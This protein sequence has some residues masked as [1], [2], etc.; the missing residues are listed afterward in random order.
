MVTTAE[1]QDFAGPRRAVV[2]RCRIHRFWFGSASLRASAGRG[3]D[4]GKTIGSG[5]ATDQEGGAGE[6]QCLRIEFGD[7]DVVVRREVV[8]FA[9]RRAPNQEGVVVGDHREIEVTPVRGQTA[10]TLAKDLAGLPGQQ[11]EGT[12]RA[13]RTRDVETKP[14]VGGEIGLATPQRGAWQH[15]ETGG[16]VRRKG[17]GTLGG[18]TEF[19]VEQ[20]AVFGQGGLDQH[21]ARPGCHLEQPALATIVDVDEIA[22]IAEDHGAVLE[23]GACCGHE[24]P[25]FPLGELRAELLKAQLAL[26]AAAWITRRGHRQAEINEKTPVGR[27]VGTTGLPAG[28]VL[29]QRD[30]R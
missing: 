21:P 22:G 26:G 23:V 29:G 1:N 20:P 13:T 28:L 8:V 15:L 14:T 25:L 5:T 11:I 30:L 10:V 24:H 19:G 4:V 9:T 2:P 18:K 6:L 3:P 16:V 17:R 12:H 27:D 7:E